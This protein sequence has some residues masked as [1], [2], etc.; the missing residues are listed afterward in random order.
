MIGIECERLL[1]D[2]HAGC[3]RA[4]ARDR[5]RPGQ[6]AA[7]TYWHAAARYSPELRMPRPDGGPHNACAFPPDLVHVCTPPDFQCLLPRVIAARMAQP[8][9]SGTRPARMRHAMCGPS[10]AVSRLCRK[11]HAEGGKSWPSAPFRPGHACE[12]TAGSRPCALG[13]HRAN[14]H[15]QAVNGR[16]MLPS[17]PRQPRSQTP[18]YSAFVCRHATA[19]PQTSAAVGD[20]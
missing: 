4:S 7:F 17:S 8:L 10:N 13:R 6:H 15:R 5:C 1:A 11:P 2:L 12:R 20:V 19:A 14:G 18:C 3:W 16:D 9:W